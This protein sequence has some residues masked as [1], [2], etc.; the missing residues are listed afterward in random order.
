[1]TPTQ[2]RDGWQIHLLVLADDRV[3][4]EWDGQV[5]HESAGRGHLAAVGE[6]LDP[7]VVG[8][9]G[10]VGQHDDRLVS[11]DVMPALWWGRWG[12]GGEGEP[13]VCPAWAVIVCPF[14]QVETCQNC[15]MRVFD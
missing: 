8:V 6:E 4:W 13:P 2:G 5:L 15:P 9:V 10:D 14:S 11:G 3:R 12:P 7:E 1:M